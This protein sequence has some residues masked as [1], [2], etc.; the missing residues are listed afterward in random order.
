MTHTAAQPDEG[1]STLVDNLDN[2]TIWTVSEPGTF[3]YISNGFED[4][5]GISAD[6]IRDNP[7]RLLETI[8][9]EDRDFVRS[10]MEQ[11]PDKMSK[12]EYEGRIVRPD[13]EVRWMKNQQVPIW[14]SEGDLSYVIGIS[15]DIT[16]QKQREKELEV[17]NRILRHD[18]RNDMAVILGWMEF[19][20]DHVDEEGHEYLQKTISSGR[21]IVE[22]TESA[23][24]Y[25]ELIVDGEDMEL[26]PVSLES[27]LQTEIHLRR[28]MYSNA[29][30]KIDGELPDAELLANDL[31]SSVFRNVL[32]NAV[33]H[34][35]TQNPKIEISFAD[36]GT[37]VVTQIADNGPGIPDDEKESI[38]GE[39]TK[40]LASSS[41]GMGLYLTEELVRNFGGEIW[42]ENNEPKGSIF[43]IKLPKAN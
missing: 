41:T 14:D 34:N 5:W 13:G 16:E 42:V 15:T 7:D 35:D 21:H 31:L 27:I 8:H 22:L 3:E 2:T 9:P 40:G 19:L 39:Q 37:D 32:N 20:E 12:V 38:F 28:E 24:N 23:R 10:Q 43:N 29:E 26:E 30:F 11:D 1:L 4:L 18:I 36:T 17:L 6:T 25:V 33:Q